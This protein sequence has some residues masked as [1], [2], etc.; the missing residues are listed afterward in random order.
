MGI[1]VGTWITPA[2][3]FPE[4]KD[5]HGH[6]AKIIGRALGPIEKTC[7]RSQ[8]YRH[9]AEEA[10]EQGNIS[11]DIGG[12]DRHSLVLKLTGEQAR[13]RGKGPT[14][15]VAWRRECMQ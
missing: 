6:P 3:M 9:L 1:R 11:G 15:V 5:M 4:A 13:K 7:G 14:P 8:K 10:K 12:G 2:I